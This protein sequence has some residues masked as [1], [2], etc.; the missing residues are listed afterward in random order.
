MELGEIYN[1]AT[2]VMIYLFYEKHSSHIY[3]VETITATK[4]LPDVGLVNNTLY[5][6]SSVSTPQNCTDMEYCQMVCNCG[7][8]QTRAYSNFSTTLVLSVTPV[9]GFVLLIVLVLLI[10][11]LIRIRSKHHKTFEAVLLYY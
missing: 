8:N 3:N 5:S 9:V 4:N 7:E 11:I 2:K 6:T 10:I 1:S